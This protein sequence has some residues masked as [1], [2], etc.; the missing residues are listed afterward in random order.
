MLELQEYLPLVFFDNSTSRTPPRNH[1]RALVPAD[2]STAVELV[3]R[4]KVPFFYMLINELDRLHELAIFD[5]KLE[6]QILCTIGGDLPQVMEVYIGHFA[7]V[8][9]NVVDERRGRGLPLPL[10]LLV[11]Q[12]AD[13]AP[14]AKNTH[15][16]ESDVGHAA[17][18]RI[19][20]QFRLVLVFV[21]C[22]SLAIIYR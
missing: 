14:A 13:E 22:L 21:V 12:E 1:R 15:Q 18:C 8:M 4:R 6:R 9:W 19:P 10:I 20:R 17:P 2:P 16:N 5:L 7:I 3:Q 11:L